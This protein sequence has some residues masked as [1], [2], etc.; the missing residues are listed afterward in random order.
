MTWFSRMS[1]QELR[2]SLYRIAAGHQ[3]DRSAMLSRIARH[4]TGSPVAERPP[5][6]HALRLAGSALAVITILGVGGVA[7]WSLADGPD[8]GT[9]PVAP[10]AARPSTPLPGPSTGTPSR[11]PSKR[12]S[13]VPGAAAPSVAASRAPRARPPA[14]PPPP[15]PPPPPR[16]KAEPVSADGSVNPNTDDTAGRSDITVTVREPLS[17]L[18]VTVRIAPATGLTDQGGT[19]DAGDAPFGTTVVREQETLVY[20]FKLAGGATLA[21][22]TYVFTA[23]FAYPNEGGRDAGADTYQVTGTTAGE[24][25]GINLAGDFS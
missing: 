7:R 15:A 17:A 13:A 23:K 3:P 18:T 4:R 1:E 2:A 16:K 6:G 5:A 9:E 11:P 25:A 8:P 24:P 12:P 10:P 19:H 20:R 14:A 21:A 22:G